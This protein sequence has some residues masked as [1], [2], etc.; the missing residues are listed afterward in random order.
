ML[1]G[2]SFVVSEKF[3]LYLMPCDM[4]SGALFLL[5][6]PFWRIL[7]NSSSEEEPQKMLGAALPWYQST[8]GEVL[9]DLREIMICCRCDRVD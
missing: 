6:I 5:S 9:D 2:F 7:W 8:V 1:F 4:S 3:D